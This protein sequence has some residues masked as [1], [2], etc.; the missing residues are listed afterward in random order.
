MIDTSIT[1]NSKSTGFN[2][3]VIMGESFPKASLQNLTAE[4]LQNL[5]DASCSIYKMTTTFLMYDFQISCILSNNTWKSACFCTYRL[6]HHLY[7]GWK[8]STWIVRLLLWIAK[9]QSTS[10][11]VVNVN[12]DS[13]V[14]LW[15]LNPGTTEYVKCFTILN[16]I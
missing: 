7:N 6:P 14:M 10:M 2:L 16:F 5:Q 12:F 4:L 1:N 3:E 11:S 9:K 8:T 15:M 13:A